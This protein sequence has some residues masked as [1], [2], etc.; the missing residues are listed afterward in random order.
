MR[1]RYRVVIH[2]GDTQSAE[3][4]KLYKEYAGR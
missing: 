3:I 2:P 4:P 1:F